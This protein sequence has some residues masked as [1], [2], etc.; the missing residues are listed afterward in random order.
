MSEAGDAAY[1]RQAERT[2]EIVSEDFVAHIRSSVVCL[3]ALG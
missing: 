2:L 3:F 1:L